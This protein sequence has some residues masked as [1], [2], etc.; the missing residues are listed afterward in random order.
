ME[1]RV[2]RVVRDHEVSPQGSVR[3]CLAPPKLTPEG[4]AGAHLCPSR[5]PTC[6]DGPGERGG[7]DIQL[8]PQDYPSLG[9]LAHKLAESNIQPIFAVTKR[10][11]PTYEVHD[12]TGP[13]QAG[14]SQ[15]T[16]LGAWAGG[17]GPAKVGKT[18]GQVHK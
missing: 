6:W 16:V 13:H 3:V 2:R 10:M 11:V 5:W 7:T 17:W 18:I 12:G 1:L 4:A 8:S 9:Q 14:Q 15:G